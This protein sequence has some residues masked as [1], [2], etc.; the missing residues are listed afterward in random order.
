M[1]TRPGRVTDGHADRPRA[2]PQPGT[3][4]QSGVP[5]PLRRRLGCAVRVTSGSRGRGCQVAIAARHP[6]VERAVIAE[7]MGSRE[8][9]ALASNS[10]PFLLVVGFLALWELL[11]RTVFAGRFLVPPPESVFWGIWQDRGIYQVSVPTTVHEA[12]LGFL[13]GERGGHL[14]GTVVPPRAGGRE[15]SDAPG[16]REL[17]PA[18]GRHR[19]HPADPSEW[20]VA[21]DRLSPPSRCSSRHSSSC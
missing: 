10:G 16:D 20:R 6:A 14:G 1:S 17:L 3:H 7:S 11:A 19:S 4:A 13:T 2:A 21:Q 18:D 15:A 9:E 5:R 12:A 8:L